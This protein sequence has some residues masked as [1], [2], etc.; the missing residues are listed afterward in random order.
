MEFSV[1]WGKENAVAGENSVSFRAQ[2]GWFT[3]LEGI[4]WP[5]SSKNLQHLGIDVEFTT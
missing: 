3:E 1:K 5:C 4:V 2:V